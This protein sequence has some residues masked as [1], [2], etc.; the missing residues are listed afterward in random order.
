MGHTIPVIMKTRLLLD[1]DPTAV[2]AAVEVL[3]R[4]GVCALPT[5]TVY[6]LAGRG[7]DDD[8]VGAIYAAKGRPADNP[9][10]LH[11]GAVDD[12][13]PLWRL[14]PPEQRRVEL[15]AHAFWPGP[16]TLVG[17]ASEVVPPLPRAG[18]ARVAV[19]LPRHPFARAVAQ[20]LGEPFAAPSA[21]LSGRPSPTT[22][23]DVLHTLQ[24]RIPLVI[25]GGPCSA[26][27]ESSVVDVSGPRPRLLRP[28]AL[29]V[30]EL[31]RVVPDLDVRSPGSAAHIDD[32][33]PGLRHRHYAP[34]LPCSLVTEVHSVWNDEGVAVIVDADTAHRL[35]PRPGFVVILPPVAAAWA[36]GLYAALYKAERAHPTR[37]VILRVPGDDD[38]WAAVRDRLLRATA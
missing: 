35:G 29:S 16:L 21:N 19:R 36:R 25:D 18:L 8:S 28:G 15:L 14:T 11:V 13:W 27:I 34:A 1:S 33:S 3:A 17:T 22:A 31:K 32:A 24:G 20:A 26:G 5:E 12:A 37:L 7:L 9:L 10:I 38:E 30:L 2:S 23:Q 6:G 4:G